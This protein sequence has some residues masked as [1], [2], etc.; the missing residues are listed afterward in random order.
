VD[1]VPGVAFD[2]YDTLNIADVPYVSKS[3]R[4]LAAWTATLTPDIPDGEFLLSFTAET[5]VGQSAVNE[6]VRRLLR[7]FDAIRRDGLG[8][9]IQFGDFGTASG[10]IECASEF[11]IG[12]RTEVLVWSDESPLTSGTVDLP[13]HN[14][15]DLLT[16][17]VKC[18]A[19]S[20]VYATPAGWT[21]LVDNSPDNDGGV[22][23]F[24]K[25]SDGTEGSTVTL[26]MS[27]GNA[28]WIAGISMV[29][30]GLDYTTYPPD[31]S[32]ILNNGSS[33]TTINPPQITMSHGV[34]TY[35][36]YV[37]VTAFG[38]QGTHLPAVDSDG[39]TLL[40]SIGVGTGDPWMALYHK[41]IADVDT[42]DP[43]TFTMAGNGTYQAHTIAVLSV[44][45][46]V[47]PIA[48]DHVHTERQVSDITTLAQNLV[49][50]NADRVKIYDSEDTDTH[51][52][53]ELGDL[54]GGGGT[55][56]TAI[57]D[58]VSGEIA[59]ITAK[60]TPV[61]AD[62]ILIEDSEDGDAKK[63]ITIGDLPAGSSTDPDA[64]HVNVAGEIAGIAGKASPVAADLI[65]IEDSEDS[66]AKKSVQIGDLPGGS[67]GVEVKK[68]GTPVGTRTAIN[69][70]EG[71]NI[72]LGVVDD[73]GN[74][75][76]DVTIDAAGGG[77]GSDLTLLDT[78][79]VTGAAAA[80]VHSSIPTGYD[81]LL[82]VAD[83]R[84]GANTT[85][86]DESRWRCGAGT[87][88]TAAAS[89]SYGRAIIAG[90][91]NGNNATTASATF[92]YLG[93]IPSASHADDDWARCLVRVLFYDSATIDTLFDANIKFALQDG[94]IVRAHAGVGGHRVGG[95]IDIIEIGGG[96]T[97][98][99]T[100]G[101]LE[102]G[103]T[104][105]LFGRTYPT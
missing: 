76:V 20:T 31:S 92:M 13:T 26:T 63:S 93:T 59:A 36:V 102:I 98:S 100:P 83:I 3:D 9:G 19:T 12:I 29:H 25:V 40:T 2:V 84:S 68:N 81:E 66:D 50:V 41:R 11:G 22:A 70:I 94:S 105:R 57:H 61:S 75:E 85:Q 28:P 48:D 67:G 101:I 33:A 51:K 47:D 7:E 77:G 14:A 52:W 44:A 10:C 6:G 64:I 42:E 82:I 39:Y 74:D 88:S 8:G 62:W 35:D 21:E 87:V 96:A 46:L 58:D 30:S 55:D 71:T 91:N 4:R 37:V 103:S 23:S 79:T 95:A 45:D 72:T 78:Q 24:F 49:P 86:G 99:G 54:P 80:I 104:S 69:F 18:D 97:V 15:G 32:S 43:A 60:A 16:F 65:V 27:G 34:T 38:A 90:T 56:P 53:A 73:A 1:P 5:F 89:Y 17:S